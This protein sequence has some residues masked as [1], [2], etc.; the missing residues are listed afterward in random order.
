MAENTD[1]TKEEAPNKFVSAEIL[2]GIFFFGGLDAIC[3]VIDF[4]GVGLAIA[5]V[6]QSFGTF[7]ATM[8]LS[9]KGDKN[10]VKLGRQITKYAANALPIVPTLT[11]AFIIEAYL[12]NHPKLKAVAAPKIANV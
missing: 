8:W 10:T 11:T 12:H 6:L 4:T 5:P 3:V 1:T 9:S 2:L 7:A